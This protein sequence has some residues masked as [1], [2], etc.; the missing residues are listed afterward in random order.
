M[1]YV[2]KMARLMCDRMSARMERSVRTGR[3]A[4]LTVLGLT[5]SD[6]AS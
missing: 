1:K 2:M 4:D 6:S 3:I 5:A